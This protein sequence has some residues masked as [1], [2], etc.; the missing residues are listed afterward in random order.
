MR[1]LLPLPAGRPASLPHAFRIRGDQPARFLAFIEPGRLLHLYDEVGIPATELR[2]PGADGQ[3]LG[4]EIPRLDAG[5]T[6][7][8]IEVVSPPIPE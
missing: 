4:V 7:V 1:R 3:S 8:R 6:A 2:L 5:L